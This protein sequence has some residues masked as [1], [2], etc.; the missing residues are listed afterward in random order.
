MDNSVLNKTY[1]TLLFSSVVFSITISLAGFTPLQL[2]G[3]GSFPIEIFGINPLIASVAGMGYISLFALS[4]VQIALLTVILIKI[5]QFSKSSLPS[6]T[7]LILLAMLLI[8]STVAVNL[9]HL[10]IP[11]APDTSDFESQILSI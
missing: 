2:I 4:L 1:L 3:L 9:S 8:I 11:E 10:L 7:K 6:K 5:Y